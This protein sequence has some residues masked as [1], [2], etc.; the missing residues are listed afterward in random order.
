MAVAMAAGVGGASCRYCEQQGMKSIRQ[1]SQGL[2]NAR[3]CS[4][5]ISI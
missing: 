3:I 5:A 2:A 1:R 4:I